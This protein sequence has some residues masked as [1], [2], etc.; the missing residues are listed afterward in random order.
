MTSSSIVASCNGLYSV[1]SAQLIVVLRDNQLTTRVLLYD[2]MSFVGVMVAR[3][4]NISHLPQEI[5]ARSPYAARVHLEDPSP[6]ILPL[7]LVVRVQTHPDVSFDGSADVHW[8]VAQVYTAVGAI[9][10]F[11]RGIIER[12]RSAETFNSDDSETQTSHWLS[13]TSKGKREGKGYV[14][15][16]RMAVS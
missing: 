7:K 3:R 1:C 13:N 14:V 16:N 2:R 15:T 12:G 5:F 9:L 11:V 4:T 10:Q 6:N 8:D